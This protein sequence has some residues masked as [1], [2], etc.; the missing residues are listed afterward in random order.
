MNAYD[1]REE[2]TAEDGFKTVRKA[3]VTSAGLV[4][5]YEVIWRAPS[6]QG[7]NSRTTKSKGGQFS[8]LMPSQILSFGL[9][10]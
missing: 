1:F 10:A 3:T 2:V 4:L 7:M 6:R 5:I 8:L 9:R